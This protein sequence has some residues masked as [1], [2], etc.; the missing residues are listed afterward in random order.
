MGKYYAQEISWHAICSII[1]IAVLSGMARLMLHSR[2]L[3]RSRGRTLAQE[4][5]D[6]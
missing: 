2:E 5:E 4:C 1:L 3:G 6:K